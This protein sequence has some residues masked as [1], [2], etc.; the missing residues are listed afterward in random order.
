MKDGFLWVYKPVGKTSR[1][2]LDELQRKL[3]VKGGYE[4]TLDPFAEGLLIVAIGKATRFLP[5]FQNLL[6]TYEATLVLGGETDTLDV[7]GKVVVEKPIPTL[8]GEMVEGVLRSFLGEYEQIP[9]KFSA[10]RVRGKRAYELARKGE[11]VELKPRRVYIDYIYLKG[12]WENKIVFICR[13]SSGT[14]IRALGRDIAYR[15]GTV[16]YLESLKRIEI[17]PIKVDMAKS[18]DDIKEEDIIPMGKGLFWIDRVD[19]TGD[20]GIKFLMGNTVRF[21]GDGG[22]KRVYVDGKF[23]GLGIVEGGYLKPERLLPY[24]ET[25]P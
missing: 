10:I 25:K 12:I 9:P 23:V 14:Y 17:G 5:Y 3:K 24:L 7:E 21:K 16:G 1:E 2:V 4:G 11:D 8:N 6:K 22:L 15:L 13:V 20:V 18:V 19:L